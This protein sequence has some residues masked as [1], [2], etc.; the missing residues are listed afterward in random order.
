MLRF[1]KPPYNIHKRFMITRR[2]FLLLLS[3]SFFESSCSVFDLFDDHTVDGKFF[4]EDNVAYHFQENCFFSKN[5][6][7][8]L[9]NDYSDYAEL[10]CLVSPQ[11]S[12][13]HGVYCIFIGVPKTCMKVRNN[14]LSFS[15]ICPVTVYFLTLT[16][17]DM[18]G[19]YSKHTAIAHINGS[20][21]L[22]GSAGNLKEDMGVFPSTIRLKLSLDDGGKIRLAFNSLTEGSVMDAH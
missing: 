14:R 2:L 13:N 17:R 11:E 21:Q 12:N 19:I 4:N 8:A 18:V 20:A 22:S 5:Y 15:P 1:R 7:M 9:D 16:N 10:S 3:V 6:P